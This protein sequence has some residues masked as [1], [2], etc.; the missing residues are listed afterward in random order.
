MKDL[1]FETPATMKK[2]FPFLKDVDS[3]A[4]CNAQLAFKEAV[5]RFNQK[6]DKNSDGNEFI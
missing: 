2:N 5:Q 3:L 4:L 6:Y 1:S